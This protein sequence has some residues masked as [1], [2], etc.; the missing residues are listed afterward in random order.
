VVQV[1]ATCIWALLGRRDWRWNCWCF[2]L[3]VVQKCTA[4]RQLCGSSFVIAPARSSYQVRVLALPA[5]LTHQLLSLE[6]VPAPSTAHSNSHL[7]FSFVWGNALCNQH[8]GQRCRR[9]TAL[10]FAG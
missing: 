9:S 4:R 1:L 10:T 3:S 2:R 8:L 5:S 7:E 6:D